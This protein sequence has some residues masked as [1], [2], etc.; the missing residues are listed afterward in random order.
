MCF[1]FPLIIGYRLYNNIYTRQ[2]SCC[3]IAEIR[4]DVESTA[5]VFNIHRF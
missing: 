4:A 1:G 3:L 2:Q 5:Q